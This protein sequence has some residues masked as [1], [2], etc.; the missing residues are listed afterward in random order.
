MRIVRDLRDLKLWAVWGLDG[1]W[2]GWGLVVSSSLEEVTSFDPSPSIE[3]SSLSVSV[4]DSVNPATI[5]PIPNKVLTQKKKARSLSTFAFS[6]L[7]SVKCLRVPEWESGRERRERRGSDHV[8][9][10]SARVRDVRDVYVDEEGMWV[11]RGRGRL[12]SV[13]E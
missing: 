5:S 11:W 6:F 7:E 3:E 13:S 2:V 12:E 4:S 8:W 9:G 1:G 10:G